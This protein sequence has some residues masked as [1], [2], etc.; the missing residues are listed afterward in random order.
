MY[1]WRLARAVFSALAGDGA[2]VAG[3]RWNWPGLPL[4]YASSTVSL[5]TLEILAH[6]DLRALPDDLT[7]YQIHIPDDVTIERVTL[8]E[9]DPAW[10]DTSDHA[11]C[12]ARGKVWIETASTAVLVVPSIIVPDESNYLL[13]PRHPDFAR[14][15]VAQTRDFVMDARL[16]L[17]LRTKV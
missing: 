10:R 3:G 7:A 14:I 8:D 4:V 17:A 13:N 11:V 12:R 15:V 2:R 9:L 1:V 16:L 6:T 5:A